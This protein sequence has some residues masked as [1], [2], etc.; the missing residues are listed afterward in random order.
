MA[1]VVIPE[2]PATKALVAAICSYEVAAIG[3]RGRLPTVTALGHRWPALK[4]AI[5]IALAV[6]FWTPDPTAPLGTPRNTRED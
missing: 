5:I 3:S 2:T 1:R 6:H 4:A